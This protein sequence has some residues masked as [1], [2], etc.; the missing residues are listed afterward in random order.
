MMQRRA[1][2]SLNTDRLMGLVLLLCLFAMA[3]QPITDPDFWWHLRTGQYIWETR[4]IPRHDI[5]SHTVPET[6]W[7]THEWLTELLLYSV[8]TLSGQGGLIVVFATVIAGTFMLLYLQCAGRPYLAAFVVVLA[9]ITSAL[10]WGVRPQ[11][12]SLMLSALFLYILH[13]YR[14]QKSWVIW[15]LPPL[16]ALWANLHGSF[17]LGVVYPAL[18]ILGEAVDNLL[19]PG[20][21]GA[22][23]WRDMRR[24]ALVTLITA[25]A[26]ILNPN[27]LQL[28]IYPFGTLGS[29]AMQAYI[30]E[31]FSPDFHLAQFQPFALYILA[32][33]LSLGLS[34][35]TPSAR[36]LLFLVGFGYASLRSARFI[37][38]FV[39]TS[40][41][42][43]DDQLLHM[44]LH[45]G[46]SGR[47]AKRSTR[48]GRA[49]VAANW[50]LL[51][52]L[53]LG[54]AINTG[55]ALRRN[56]E[57]YREVFPVSAVDFL[58][59]RQTI[60]KMYNLYHWGGYLIWRL[61]PEHKVFIDGRAD[62]YGDAFI[63][64]YLQVYQLRED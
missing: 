40:A 43:L 48:P 39:L 7:I 18:Y 31:W 6:P 9:A 25:I 16:M 50:L 8:Y 1:A 45:S 34:K 36:E 33:L 11:M 27:G 15:L 2:Y 4:S 61:Y 38:F 53:A 13:L 29:A 46:W 64:E 42:T 49:Y 52:V 63:E 30:M 35:R 56:N 21:E 62:V 17:F 3:T 54:V 28:L 57:A 47:F 41:S 14:N 10:T 19:R 20:R 59:D 51:G 26:P 24:L 55:Y 12:L 58:A 32:L 23:A 5:F 37:P 44:W 60:G 22:M